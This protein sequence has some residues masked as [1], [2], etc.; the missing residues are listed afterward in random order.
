[1]ERPYLLDDRAARETLGM[2]PTPWEAVLREVV[3]H[4]RRTA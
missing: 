3:E 2:E 1:M 4:Y